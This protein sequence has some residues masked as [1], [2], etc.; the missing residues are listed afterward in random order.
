MTEQERGRHDEVVERNVEGMR[1]L[2]A[3]KHERDQRRGAEPPSE[4][5]PN[6]PAQADQ[7]ANEPTGAHGSTGGIR[8]MGGGRP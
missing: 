4:D 5:D 3:R 2:L 7:L 6:V 1:D 8:N